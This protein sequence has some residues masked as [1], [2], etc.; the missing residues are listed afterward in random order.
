MG[1]T[2]EIIYG[3]MLVVSQFI[4]QMLY[5]FFRPGATLAA[6]QVV[7]GRCG[8]SAWDAD[9]YKVTDSEAKWNYL[10]DGEDETAERDP[11]ADL[12]ADPFDF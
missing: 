10:E 7:Q 11:F 12:S 2:E 8:T 9:K 4:G 6:S 5:Y 3:S 1:R